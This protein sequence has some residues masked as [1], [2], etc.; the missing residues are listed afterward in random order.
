[1]CHSKCDQRGD[2][3]G[4]WADDDILCVLKKFKTQLRQSDSII[5]TLNKD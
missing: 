4:E 2:G 1:M 5:S 3:V